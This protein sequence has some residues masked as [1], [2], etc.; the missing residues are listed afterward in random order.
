M[1]EKENY[2]G[3][4]LGV[5]KGEFLSFF[6]GIKMFSMDKSLG[7]KERTALSGNYHWSDSPL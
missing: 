4:G 6:H 7:K 5:R 1:C 3:G 2:W